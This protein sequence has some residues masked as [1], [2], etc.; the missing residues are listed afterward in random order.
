M[1]DIETEEYGDVIVININGEFY[2]E[3]IQFAEAVW[4]EQVA[5]KPRLIGINCKNINFIDSS[6]I[7]ILVK[8]LNNA[9]Q[10]NV[11]LVF[12]DLS[13]TII[14]V[15]KTARL[16]SFFKIMEKEEFEKKFLPSRSG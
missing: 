12:Y 11:D 4:N 2:L 14:N 13:K 5:K 6:A 8:F 16:S 3:S 1:V 10:Y 7:G 15:F 9:V